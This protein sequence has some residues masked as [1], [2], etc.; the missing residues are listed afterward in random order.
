[1]AGILAGHRFS[2]Y[3]DTRAV[4]VDEF[5]Q[6]IS[7]WEKDSLPA[8]NSSNFLIAANGTPPEPMIRD[9]SS[10]FFGPT[11]LDISQA[12]LRP[13]RPPS[14]PPSRSHSPLKLSRPS[15][16]ASALADART[17]TSSAMA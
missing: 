15:C 6:A 7:K 10:D 3:T 17:L 9:S 16:D 12:H 5:R 2:S 13:I 8:F 4:L 1:M 11:L 14:L